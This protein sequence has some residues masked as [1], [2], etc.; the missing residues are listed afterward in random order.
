VATIANKIG[1]SPVQVYRGVILRAIEIAASD[2]E[3]IAPIIV[4]A[5]NQ[6]IRPLARK[7]PRFLQWCP[8]SPKL[9]WMI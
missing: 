6:P 4:I 7:H 5:N 1:P 2:Q 3:L 9:L 8:A